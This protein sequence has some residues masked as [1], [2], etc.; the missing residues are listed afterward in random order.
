MTALAEKWKVAKAGDDELIWLKIPKELA[1]D[2]GLLG[3][4]R[5]SV[6]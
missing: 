6:V 3:V 2:G 4:D 5:K 1:P